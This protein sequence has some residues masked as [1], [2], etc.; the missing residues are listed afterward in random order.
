M[1]CAKGYKKFRQGQFQ[2]SSMF[3]GRALQII[4]VPLDGVQ[5]AIETTMSS[6]SS[7]SSRNICQHT[8]PANDGTSV[9]GDQQQLC[10]CG[11]GYRPSI[12]PSLTIDRKLFELYK[13]RFNSCCSQQKNQR[14]EGMEVVEPTTV[15]SQILHDGDV[16]MDVSPSSPSSWVERYCKPLP[17]PVQLFS[18]DDDGDDDD[19]HPEHFWKC[20]KRTIK[21]YRHL[22]HRAATLSLLVIFNI[23]TVL[24]RM[25]IMEGRKERTESSSPCFVTLYRLAFKTLFLQD[26]N[27]CMSWMTSPRQYEYFITRNKRIKLVIL[28]N[29]GHYVKMTATPQQG[30]TAVSI[31]QDTEIYSHG[32]EQLGEEGDARQFFEQLYLVLL[33]VHQ[34]QREGTTTTTT[35]NGDDGDYCSYRDSIPTLH[36]FTV[37][38]PDFDLQGLVDCVV[39]E[40]RMLSPPKTAPAA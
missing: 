7:S 23:A 21:T 27:S 37:H 39:V 34:K 18:V 22:K 2:D 10:S 1:L 36:D 35:R 40:L 4:K 17:F 26:E 13:V 28:N 9:S 12:C 29:L 6:L 32:N 38:E 3:Y 11:C 5:T 33:K 8:H 20:Q 24:Q 16:E 30:R 14:V 19:E 15:S 31:H 25:S